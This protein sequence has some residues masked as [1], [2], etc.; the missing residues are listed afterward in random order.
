MRSI[1]L[2]LILS[3]TAPA[4]ELPRGSTQAVVGITESWSSSQ[5]TVYIYQKGGKTW[6]QV[7]GPW[8]G[9]CGKKGLA[10]GRGIHPHS[11]RR[12]QT[13]RRLARPRRRLPHRR[14]L[15]L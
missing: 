13:R 6:K 15:G 14:R 4:F 11:Q 10:W 5:V 12:H 9:R 7:A 3:L 1:L 2:S 8:R